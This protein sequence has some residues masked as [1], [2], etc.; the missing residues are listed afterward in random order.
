[1]GQRKDFLGRQSFQRL[2]GLAHHVFPGSSSHDWKRPCRTTHLFR[3]IALTNRHFRSDHRFFFLFHHR[4]H[5]YEQLQE[6]ISQPRNSQQ[7]LAQTLRENLQILFGALPLR[8]WLF[9]SLFQ[10]SR[11]LQNPDVNVRL[12][13]ASSLHDRFGGCPSVPTVSASPHCDSSDQSDRVCSVFGV[14]QPDQ[15][16]RRDRR[17]FGHH[18]GVLYH[19]VLWVSDA[20]DRSQT[21][22]RA[23]VRRG[24]G[25][26]NS[27]RTGARG[28]ETEETERREAG[29]DEKEVGV[30]CQEKAESEGDR[31]EKESF[32]VRKSSK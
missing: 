22:L 19:G 8:L 10:R 14:H 15:H 29:N 32:P 26:K 7:N 28:R 3:L 12:C 20:F 13:L 30:G 27:E 5:L 18:A 1:M 4:F 11:R 23:E 6:R 17:A 16:G 21:V 2:D 9:D 25:T 24:I 31:K